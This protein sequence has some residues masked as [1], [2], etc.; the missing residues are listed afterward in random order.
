MSEVASKIVTLTGRI[1]QEVER[2]LDATKYKYTHGDIIA[3]LSSITVTLPLYEDCPSKGSVRFNLSRR[4]SEG[5][6]L[7]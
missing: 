6:Y 2:V 1:E 4:F 7:D 5:G 3:D